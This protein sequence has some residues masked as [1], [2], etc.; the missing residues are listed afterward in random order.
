MARVE[1]ELVDVREHYEAL[2]HEQR[3]KLKSD[4]ERKALDAAA[5]ARTLDTS[6]TQT[7]EQRAAAE[8]LRLLE[9]ERTKAG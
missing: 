3:A 6:A 9:I 5:K 8:A 1:T 2:D 4:A 7:P